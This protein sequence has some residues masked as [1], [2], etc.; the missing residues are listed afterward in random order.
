MRVSAGSG[1]CPITGL[2]SARSNNRSEAARVPPSETAVAFVWQHLAFGGWL[3]S[4]IGPIGQIRRM[5]VSAGGGDCPVTGLISARP[6]NRSEAARVA[7][8]ET[9]VAFVWQHLAVGG[10]RSSRIGPIGRMGRMRVS[11]GGGDCPVTGLISARP[12]NRGCSRNTIRNRSR[13]RVAAFGGWR[14]RQHA[15]VIREPCYADCMQWQARFIPRSTSRRF[16]LGF[17]RYAVSYAPSERLRFF[18]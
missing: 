13:L 9:A 2:I 15:V 14:S 18:V 1:D 8:S 11:A 5:R 4:R 17:G 7:P 6:N 16:S 12:E 10:W 3:S